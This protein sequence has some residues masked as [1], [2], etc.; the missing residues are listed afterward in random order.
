M[1]NITDSIEVIPSTNGGSTIYGCPMGDY[2]STSFWKT[3]RH[4]LLH[5]VLLPLK[6][7]C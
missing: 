5:A 4:A 2:Y 6:M 7:F 3:Y 1:K